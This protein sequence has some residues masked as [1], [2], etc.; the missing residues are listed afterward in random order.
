MAVSPAAREKVHRHL[1]VDSPLP[2]VMGTDRSY[3]ISFVYPPPASTGANFRPPENLTV[4][5]TAIFWV[6]CFG[7]R[8]HTSA[9]G[10]SWISSRASAMYDFS[11]EWR[12]QNTLKR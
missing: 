9:E 3:W 2:L 12:V 7:K 4:R 11:T 10:G 8:S 5:L 6:T 1:R